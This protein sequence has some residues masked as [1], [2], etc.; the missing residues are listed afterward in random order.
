MLLLS[1]ARFRKAA[2]AIKADARPFEQAVFS[3]RFEQKCIEVALAAL[4]A[5]QNEDGGFGQGLEPDFFYPGSSSLAT[6]I[7][8]CYG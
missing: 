2:D 7:A 3:F 8:L 1:K 6:S 5:Y 4:A